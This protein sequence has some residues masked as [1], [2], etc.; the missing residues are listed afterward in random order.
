MC[1]WNGRVIKGPHGISYEGAEP[2]PIRVSYGITYD[3]L[4][5]KIYGIT[6]LEKE[7]FKVKIICRYP[8]CREYISVPIENDESIDIMFDVARQPGT[9]CM[10]LYIEKE[11]AH[12]DNQ[13]NTTELIHDDNQE[14][15]LT[16][17][18]VNDNQGTEKGATQESKVDNF[19]D[20]GPID[21]SVLML[22]NQHR[23]EAIWAG[24]DPGVLKC[25]QRLGTMMKEWQLDK[26]ICRF[27]IQSGFYGIYKIGFIQLDWP[28]ITALV[29]RWRQETHTFHFPVGESTITLQDVAVLLGL[30]IEGQALTG[31]TDLQWAD[32][33]EELLGLRP[34]QSV[35]HGSTL[36]LSWLRTH[37]LQPPIDADD[38][39]L[40]RYA[41]GYIL[42]LIGSVLFTDKSGA[43]VQ[44]MFL[45]M[46]RN[47]ADVPQFSWG[48]AALAHLYRELCKACKKGA[49]EIAGPLVLIQL[50]AWERLSIGRPERLSSR[51]QT[52]D[53]PDS[54]DI[55]GTAPLAEDAEVDEEELPK[56]PLGCRW[57][58]PI[59]RRDNPL[60]AL[61]FYRDQLDQQTD[62]QMI[63]QPY[64]PDLL[65]LLPD[66]CL[67]DQH[68]WRTIAPLIC[69]DV[70]EW[71]RP[72]RVLRQF[73]LH[74]EIPME[75]D[76]EAKLHA[77]DKRGRHHYEWPVY[78]RQ[79][80]QLW[81]ARKDTVATGEPGGHPMHYQDPYMKWYRR[82]TRRMITP[83]TQ[84]AHMHFQPSSGTAHLLVQSLTTIHNKCTTTLGASQSETAMQALTDIQNT[85]IQV[86]QIF[87]ETRHLEA[88][89][90]PSVATSSTSLAQSL[91]ESHKELASPQAT[92]AAAVKLTSTRSRGRGKSGRR[93]STPSQTIG[94]CLSP[95][96]AT[97]Q[98]TAQPH[99]D[100]M[101]SQALFLSNVE[102]TPSTDSVLL[103]ESE[104]GFSEETEKESN[105]GTRPKRKKPKHI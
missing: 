33:C 71:H 80:I 34:D 67:R 58:A 2:K 22:Q 30:P 94:S 51:V 85:C 52:L 48:S 45:P 46:L 37:F 72:D 31:R 23:S 57:R 74:Q 100:N 36:K 43:D 47:I 105:H 4:V 32:L 1:Y 82:I 24:E 15:V 53:L 19:L 49:N 83:L 3:E 93:G 8:A 77:I 41:R 84:S 75:C 62:D 40:V 101:D 64:T 5:D 13:A 42:A 16:P 61:I 78:H 11:P 102:A 98:P 92:P 66:I 38:V 17:I 89:P 6:G 20:P 27:V 76:T 96:V 86:L 12:N 81:E 35:L 68:V 44:L 97:A 69:F 87:G 79:Y 63:W 54:E 59:I 7:Q 50:W 14:R 21:T 65:A 73:G 39:I 28:L 18:Q 103:L 25:R 56:Y 9:H 88:K 60:R 104:E 70:I 55:A 29:E 26:R 90:S 10:E 91:G 95:H 99:I